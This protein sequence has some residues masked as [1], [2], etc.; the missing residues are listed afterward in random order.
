MGSSTLSTAALMANEIDYADGFA[1]AIRDAM[2]GIPLKAL[3]TG[4]RYSSYQLL[5]R[6]EIRTASDLKGGKAGT[7]R[8]N[9]GK[10]GARQQGD[11]V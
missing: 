11:S 2:H 3:V 8:V 9:S 6:P 5:A 1:S 7:S 10:V 4:E